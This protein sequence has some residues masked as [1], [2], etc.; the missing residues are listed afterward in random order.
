MSLLMLRL[1]PQNQLHTGRDSK[2]GHIPAAFNNKPHT[3]KTLNGVCCL[4]KAH[5]GPELSAHTLEAIVI[6]YHV[7]WVFFCFN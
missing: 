7:P 3:K 1:I 5:Q 6:L 2:M 4:C